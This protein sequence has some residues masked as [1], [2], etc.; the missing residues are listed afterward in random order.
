MEINRE[1]YNY[2]IP[3]CINCIGMNPLDK[4]SMEEV[5]AKLNE[6][7]KYIMAKSKQANEQWFQYSNK[8]CTLCGRSYDVSGKFDPS[9]NRTIQLVR[10]EFEEA[11]INISDKQLEAVVAQC[12]KAI[13]TLIKHRFETHRFNWH[14]LTFK[15]QLDMI[16]NKALDTRSGIEEAI[17]L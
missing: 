16:I 8:V 13:K 6:P 17:K 4:I 1:I 12:R 14:C 15:G 5:R 9:Y 2:T 7:A 10:M 11:G 3:W